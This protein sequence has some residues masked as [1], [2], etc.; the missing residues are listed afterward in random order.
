MVPGRDAKARAANRDLLDHGTLY[1]ARFDSNGF[2]RWFTAKARSQ[3][4][5][6]LHRKPRRS[7]TAARRRRD[8]HHEDGPP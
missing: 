8:G 6:V 7:C 1:V 4:N 5:K 2:G 3:Q